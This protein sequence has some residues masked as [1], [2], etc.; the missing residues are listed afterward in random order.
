MNIYFA[1]STRFSA[2]AENCENS[3]Y[4]GYNIKEFLF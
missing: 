2:H 1:D 4:A 3:A